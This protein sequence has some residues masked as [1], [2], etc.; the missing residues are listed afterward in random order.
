[1]RLELIVEGGVGS[2]PFP[3]NSQRFESKLE[4][5]RSEIN[6]ILNTMGL[7]KID[8]E[9]FEWTSIES[10]YRDQLKSYFPWLNEKDLEQ[11]KRALIYDWK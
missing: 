6:T 5:F 1:M 9:Q 7:L 10:F 3:K 2:M 4:P 11:F 8:L